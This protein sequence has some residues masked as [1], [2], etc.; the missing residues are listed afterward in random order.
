M[1][2][3]PFVNPFV[4][5]AEDHDVPQ[6]GKPFGI[7]VRE[8]PSIRRRQDHGSR[9]AALLTDTLD[10]AEQ[11]L[12][13]QHHPRAAPERHVVHDPVP[14]G[15]TLA[16]VVDFEVQHPAIDCAADNSFREWQLDHPRKDGHHI[17]LQQRRA[18]LP[19][20]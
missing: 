7:H 11:R 4:S 6:P 20:S 1:P 15:R 16:K 2:A 19:A 3:D 8:P 9:R 5:A 17:D 18:S 13:L 10:S 14:V 12:G